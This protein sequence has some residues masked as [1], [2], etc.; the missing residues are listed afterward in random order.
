VD[1]AVP[2]LLEFVSLTSA[3]SEM[4]LRAEMTAASAVVVLLSD[5]ARRDSRVMTEAGL[6]VSLGT[7]VIAVILDGTRPESLDF[8]EAQVWILAGGSKGPE[9]LSREIFEAASDLLTPEPE[10]DSLC[11]NPT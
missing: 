1:L 6:A 10:G 2:R 8:I 7:P 5:H 11:D 3:V 9:H 4:P